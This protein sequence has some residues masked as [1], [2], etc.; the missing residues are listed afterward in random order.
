MIL[1]YF[2]VLFNFLG[3]NDLFL[4]FMYLFTLVEIF[5]LRGKLF[6]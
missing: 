4:L 2:H 1:S 6:F 5:Y 3:N